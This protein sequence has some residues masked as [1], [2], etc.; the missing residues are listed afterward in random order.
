[1]SLAGR[2]AGGSIQAAAP[3]LSGSAEAGTERWLVTLDIDGTILDEDSQAAAETVAAVQAAIAAGHEVMLA[4]G[5][6]AP[7]VLPVVAQ[8]GIAPQYLVC[9]NGAVPPGRDARSRSGYRRTRVRTF[10]PGPVLVTLRQ[11]IPEGR[12]AVEDRQGRFRY[13]EGFPENG[14]YAER[15]P[16]ETLLETEATRVVVVSP[17]QTAEDFLDVVEQM[18][19]HRA[20]YAIGWAAWLDIA[21]EGVNKATA[22]EWV[23]RRHGI[24]G[25]RVLAM[26]DGRNDI[27]ML[28]WATESGGRGIAMGHAPAETKA[29]ASEVTAPLWEH[30]SAIALGTLPGV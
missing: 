8:F 6:S 14:A 24:P 5:R 3:A 16:F 15:V 12:Y 22:L 2:D 30:G 20:S 17:D 7:Q 9:S 21:P 28:Q 19:L 4:T 23:R 29:V 1:M 18:G 26:G 11:L 13:T 27:E 10:E 25:E